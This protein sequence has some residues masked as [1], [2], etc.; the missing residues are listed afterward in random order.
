M[1]RPVPI[2]KTS[3]IS[4]TSV[5]STP[6]KLWSSLSTL[7]EESRGLSRDL[8]ELGT[9]EERVC[10]VYRG[11]MAL[12]SI[13]LYLCSAL[14]VCFGLLL[15][16]RRRG[17]LRYCRPPSPRDHIPITLQQTCC[18]LERDPTV[19]AYG[20]QAEPRQHHSARTCPL[21][22][23]QRVVRH[24]SAPRTPRHAYSY[25]R[26]ASSSW[27]DSLVLLAQCRAP[28]GS[29]QQS[30]WHSLGELSASHLRGWCSESHTAETWFPPSKCLHGEYRVLPQQWARGSSKY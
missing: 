17:P 19:D 20:H 12:D 1:M 30:A 18:L 28:A 29:T 8:E 16:R 6:Q 25:D 2:P 5:R 9:W 23:H 10:P 7:H 3:W 11:W 27:A 26:I 14:H 13:L 15:T 4:M 21:L 24:Y 22:Q